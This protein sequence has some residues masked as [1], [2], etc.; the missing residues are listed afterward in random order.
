MNEQTIQLLNEITQNTEMAKH[1]AQDLAEIA[2]DV[3][4]KNDLH[5]QIA[6]YEDLQNRARAM[7]AVDGEEPKEESAMAK[8]S[9]KME[10]K[11]KTLTD[12]S[13]K[14]IAGMLVEGNQMGV[15][16]MARAIRDYPTAN[17]GAIA[18]AQRLQHAESEYAHQMESFL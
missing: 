2:Q 18:L 7:L 16:N 14:N 4:L 6:T 5:R 12:R 15:E 10:L 1:T 9:A 3:R 13:A 11:M 8:M 17:V